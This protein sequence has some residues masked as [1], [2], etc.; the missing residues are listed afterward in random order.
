MDFFTN[1]SSRDIYIKIRL[2]TWDTLWQFVSKAGVY[3]CLSLFV[4]LSLPLVVFVYLFGLFIL[5]SFLCLPHVQKDNSS[6][7]W[8][9]N[10]TEQKLL[11]EEGST[12]SRSR[13]VFFY[14]SLIL[15]SFWRE[16]ISSYENAKT[17]FYGTP[18]QL[19]DSQDTEETRRPLPQAVGF[20]A[21]E[22]PRHYRNRLFF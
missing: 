22:F 11:L 6:Q 5:A 18:T 16:S 3:N 12:F 1:R 13:K 9:K 19:H 10:K 4:F 15:L 7:K 20:S 21:R 14:L 17:F 2:L 8:N